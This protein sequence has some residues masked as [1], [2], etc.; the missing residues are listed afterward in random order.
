VKI[1]GVSHD[2]LNVSA[3]LEKMPIHPSRGDALM[4][5]PRA[6]FS[7][8]VSL[9]A[10]AAFSF[11]SNQA[12]CTFTTFSAPQGYAL[13]GVNDITDDGTVVGQVED[14][15]S[16]AF[17]AFSR[18]A[19]GVFTI[20]DAPNSI[21]TWFSSRNLSGVN[22]GSYLDNARIQHVHGFA[23]SGTGFVQV[24]YPKATHSWLYGI[25]TA[26]V[27]AGSFSKGGIVKGFLLSGGK[28]TTIAYP[29]VPATNPQAINDN[30]VVVGQYSDGTVDHGFIWQKGS[31]TI[32][33]YPNSRF[34]TVLSDVNNSG[35]IVGNRLSSDRAFGFIYQKGT[36][37]SIVY[38]GAKNATAG[39]INGSGVIS[40]QLYFTGGA[41]QGYTATC[42]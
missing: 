14:L 29:G 25:N 20:F 12:T 2:M 34:G 9:L 36:F 32:V 31:F 37:A 5:L 38:S 17:V 23:Q 18:S 19:A 33:D 22:V 7:L 21:F 30:S 13:V 11:A 35:V 6:A 10:F 16:G 41:T 4:G 26:G 28:Y 42:K 40:G 8:A 1:R 24:D 27:V 15:N 3:C 39:G